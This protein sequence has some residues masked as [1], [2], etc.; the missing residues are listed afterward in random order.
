VFKIASKNIN[1]TELRL[2]YIVFLTLSYTQLMLVFLR[3]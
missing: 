1:K 3:E 2:F